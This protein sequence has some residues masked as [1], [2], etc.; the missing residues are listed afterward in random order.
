MNRVDTA[1]SEAARCGGRQVLAV[2]LADSRA[3]TLALLD[4]YAA[5]LGDSLTI[6]YSP[7]LNP[8]RWEAG[9]IGWFQDYWIA[10]N[11]QRLQGIACEPG[12]E[13]AAGR[14]PRADALYDSST[15]AHATRWQ[16]DLP[17]LAATR[18]Y[19][20][21]GLAETLSLLATAQETDAALY[22][23]RLALFHEDMHGEAGIYMAQ[24]QDV[25]LP[26]SL[27]APAIAIPEAH[28]IALPDGKWPLGRAGSGFAFD[29]ELP[30][31]QVRVLAFEIDSEAV[32]WRRY[33]PFVETTG[34]VPPRYL[35]RHSGGWQRRFFGQWQDLPLDEAAT[36]L[37]ADEAEGWCRWASRRLPSEAEW[38]M[39]ALLR[40]EFRWGQ[41]W[42]WT[43]SRFAPYPGFVAHPYRD[44]SVPWFADRIVLRGATPASSPR[45]VHPRYRNFF[46]R[47]RNDL[48]SG[49]RSC[50]R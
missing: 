17:D 13:R 32:S 3:R 22:F 7:Q 28:A 49:F 34:A 1:S 12:H 44:Y 4:A 27:L 45:M 6:P 16:L 41:V 36:H 50:A 35:R 19:L 20:A 39:A 43:A 42:E 23:F 30:V 2:A 38:E 10:R 33:L 18:A 46:T 24:A 8:P 26:G 47:D 31:H 37:T 29:N 9:H 21:Q 40:P 14:L 25:P 11:R 5:A 15:V 48:Y